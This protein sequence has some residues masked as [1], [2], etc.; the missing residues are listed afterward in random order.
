VVDQGQQQIAAAQDKVDLWD[1]RLAVAENVEMAAGMGVTLGALWA[2]VEIGD[3]GARI[4]WLDW[5][6]RGRGEG[7]Y[8]RRCPKRQ[9]RGPTSSFRRTKGRPRSIR[10]R[11]SR[12]EPGARFEG[13]LCPSAPTKPWSRSEGGS[14]RPR[15]IMAL[16]RQAAGARVSRPLP[17]REKGGSRSLISRRRSNDTRRKLEA[18][19]TP[20]EQAASTRSTPSRWNARPWARRRTR[21]GQRAGRRRPEGRRPGDSQGAV[22]PGTQSHRRKVRG[23]GNPQPGAPG[24]DEGAGI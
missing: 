5:L 3:P 15:P 4:C 16:A 9:F 21:R 8:R 23:E 6:C 11:A 18:A 12:P 22:Q 24:G 7:R 20:Q 17:V 2:P 13:A 1:R 14:S 10:P 19:K